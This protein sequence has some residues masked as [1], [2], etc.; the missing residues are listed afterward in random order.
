MLS[1][2]LAFFLGVF[3]APA[4]RPLF[5]PVL[6]EMIR[7]GLVLTDEVKRMQVSLT[8]SMEDARAEAEAAQAAPPKP[9]ARPRPRPAPAAAEE[10][11]AVYEDVTPVGPKPGE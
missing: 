11:D 9:A 7:A 5:R 6:I 1:T 10:E 2:V 3:L 8:E 4:V